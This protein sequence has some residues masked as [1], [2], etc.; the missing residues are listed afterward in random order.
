MIHYS[1]YIYDITR[2]NNLGLIDTWPMLKI[3]EL[4]RLP[5]SHNMF[6]EKEAQGKYGHTPTISYRAEEDVTKEAK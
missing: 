2:E 4:D 6:E 3:S 1:G 5:W